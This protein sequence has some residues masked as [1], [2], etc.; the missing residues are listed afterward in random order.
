LNT[1]LLNLAV[2]TV[3]RITITASDAAIYGLGLSDAAAYGL[4]L[5]DAAIYGIGINDDG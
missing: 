1:S 2:L 5:S 4:N 3:V